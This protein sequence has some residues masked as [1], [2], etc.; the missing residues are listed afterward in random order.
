MKNKL[1]LPTA[2]VTALLPCL[3]PGTTAGEAAHAGA[4]AKVSPADAITRLKDGNQR[5]VT[6]KLQHP[7]QSA[8][9][10]TQ[11]ATSE[12]PFAIVLG[13]ADSRAAP[14]VIFDQGLG[15]VFV[16][17]VAGNVLNDETAG[18]IEYAVEHLGAQHIVVLGHERCGA[19]TAARE[20]IAAKSRAPGHIHSLVE[21]IQPAVEATMG[22]DVETTIKANVLNVA[23]A[24]RESTPILEEK[25]SSD[26]VSVVGA[27]Y[28]LDTGA[29][30]FLKAEAARWQ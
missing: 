22:A 18:S 14:E 2:V 9:R 6:G 27:R 17:R 26:L 25:V 4:A 15:D 10:R 13:C 16:V 1:C 19:V 21:A 11:Q 12:Q 28:D 29:V 24:L 5:F 7:R 3:V 20:T 8:Q 23:Q 30:D